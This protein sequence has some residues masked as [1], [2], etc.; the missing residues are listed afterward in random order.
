[1]F[2]VYNRVHTGLKVLEFR[3][4]SGKCFE[5]QIC[6]E[7]TGKSLKCLEKSLNS[8]IFCRT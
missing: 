4:L 2:T 8:T 1:M 3:E 5:N 7:S 6:I